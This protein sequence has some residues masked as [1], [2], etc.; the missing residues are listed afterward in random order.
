MTTVLYVKG[1]GVVTDKR[2]SGG[3]SRGERDN[4]VKFKSYE[5][6]SNCPKNEF[7]QIAIAYS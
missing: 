7:L 4:Q 2:S 1:K 6:S 3:L 5:Y